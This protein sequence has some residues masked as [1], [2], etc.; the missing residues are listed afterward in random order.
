MSKKV[1]LW[2]SLIGL[3]GVLIAAPLLLSG[4]MSRRF[5]SSDVKVLTDQVESN[6]PSIAIVRKDDK[7]V[8]SGVMPD[9]G[10]AKR[11]IA[12]IKS[13]IPE[14]TVVDK[15]KVDLNV[16]KPE[17][18]GSVQKMVR[19]MGTPGQ[20]NGFA[21]ENDVFSI[22]GPV[23][24]R[25]LRAKM[26]ADLRKL[27]PDMEF[28][29]GLN[30][31]A[32]ANT[33]PAP[34]PAAPKP[35]PAASA[36]KEP[37]RVSVRP[38]TKPAPNPAPKPVAVP[39]ANPKPKPVAKPAPKPIA[40][41]KV[42]AVKKPAKARP[43]VAKHVKKAVASKAHSKKHKAAAKRKSHRRVVVKSRTVRRATISG[44]RTNS[45]RL[46]AAQRAKLRTLA[47]SMKRNKHLRARIVGHTDSV[48]S[49]KLN[50]HLSAARAS[51][52]RA[53]LRRLGVSHKR[54]SVVGRGESTPIATNRTAH[55]REL[56]R[57]VEA[58][59]YVPMHVGVRR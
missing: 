49:R 32:P 16:D 28:V 10:L 11:M 8:V 53:Y 23:R 37:P 54:I 18:L 6:P 52:A 55:G 19:I 29:D 27:V 43:A 48:G 31:P 51:A 41:P 5:G 14:L 38:T 7:L 34:K 59:L 44:M 47:R 2:G 45:V 50:R 3:L 36:T 12:N 20:S 56:N 22:T 58:S 39:V 4:E 24:N 13:E 21:I 25:N 1:A 42:A 40:H 17:W 9:E 35:K 57:R 26:A 30:K 15:L 33:E 46:S